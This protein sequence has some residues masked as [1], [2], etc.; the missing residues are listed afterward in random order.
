MNVKG[1]FGEGQEGNEERAIGKQ[2]KSDSCYI[3]AG[4]LVE[5]YPTVLQKSEFVRNELKYL[6]EEIYKQSDESAY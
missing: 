3:V 6:A 2:R 5:L 1:A 4:N